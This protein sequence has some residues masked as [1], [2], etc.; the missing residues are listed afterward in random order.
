MVGNAVAM[1][2]KC[3]GH[4]VAR[5]VLRE[6]VASYFCGFITARSGIP[7][8]SYAEA[9]VVAAAH[10][11]V[12]GPGLANNGAVADGGGAGGGG[13]GGGG[14]GGRRGH[15]SREGEGS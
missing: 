15:A 14:R 11:Q 1:R 5:E 8:C 10:Y 12:F 4:V 13:R 3:D 7:P 6:Q 2:P 9:R